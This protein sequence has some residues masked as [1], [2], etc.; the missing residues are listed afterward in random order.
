MVSTN[1]D[2]SPNLALEIGNIFEVDEEDDNEIQPLG[3]NLLLSPVRVAPTISNSSAKNFKERKIPLFKL[4]QFSQAQRE[5]QYEKK[6]LPNL[7]SKS[8]YWK[9]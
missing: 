9:I 6:C 7:T 5:L 8:F 4:V 2:D 3:N 1:E